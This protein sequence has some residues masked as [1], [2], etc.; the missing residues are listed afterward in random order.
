M[1]EWDTAR[2][3]IFSD[4]IEPLIYYSHLTSI[5]I[6]LCLL[7]FTFLRLRDWPRAPFRLMVI[8]YIVWLFCDVVLWANESLDHVMFF[9]TVINLAEPLIF[10]GAYAY[11][12]RSLTGAPM[13]SKQRSFIFALLVPT[14]IMAPIGLSTVGFDYSNCDRNVVEGIAAYY[15]Y[16]LE[17]VFLVLIV[18]RS[19][20]MLIH[21]GYEGKRSKLTLMAM[22]VSLLLLS[23]LTANY[24]GTLFGEYTISQYGHIAVPI[25]AMF[26][27]YV[28]IRYESFK[29][30]ILLI[31]TLVV[32]LL[33][34][35]ASLFFVRVE[36]YQIYANIV[37]F[38]I[39][40][41]LGYAL[42]SGIR[43][44][45]KA[46]EEIQILARDLK[47]ANIRL[48]ELDKQKSEF[49]S[50]AT[51]QL[52]SPITSIKGNA[53]ILLEGDAGTL[54]PMAKGVIETIYTSIKTM[55]SVVEDYLNISRIEL[56]TMKYSLID[57]DFASLAKEV[58]SEQKPT[59]E[60]KGLTWKLDID[61]SQT[62][63][64]KADP[65][66]F[67][68]VLMNTID[69]SV[70]YTNTGSISVSLTKDSARKV[71]TLKVSDTGVGIAPDVI[72]K[73]FQKFSRAKTANEAN[74]HGT[75]LGLFIA[76]DIMTAHG[77]KIWAESAGEGKGSQF[78]VEI[79]ETK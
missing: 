50:F 25:F 67:K 27:A 19:G 60:A 43:K 51:H 4:N 71:I 59:I 2:L 26:L 10:V 8:S 53:S 35:L 39:A 65:D 66:K 29:P 63:R 76:K 61:E 28:T 58:M 75:G 72:P 11:F 79:P 7:G 32:S 21:K 24:F 37:A 42:M 20:V 18:V 40:I 15:N 70:K 68:Q 16:F 57:M 64:V 45:T 30:R 54:P 23:F 77:G 52:R 41:P 78:Y 55:G 1:C 3:L 48:T 9:W 46:K 69:N 62:Y 17:A 33:V 36:S 47:A 14:L 5:I 13:S 34:L 73:L 49:V 6:F 44:E 38:V 22:G 12:A 31:D 74:I 56:G